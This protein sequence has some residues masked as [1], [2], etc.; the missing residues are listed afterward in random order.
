[1]TAAG[2]GSVRPG[3][4]TARVRDA[5]REATLAELAEHGYRGLTVEGVAARSGVHKTTVYRRWRNAD[6][7]VADALERAAAEPWP[8]PDTGTLAGDLRA[9]A[10]LV[11]AGFADPR[12]GPV[13][14]AFVL[15]AA[16][17]TD[18]ARALN[19]FFARRHEQAAAVVERAAA[20]GEV[21]AGTDAAEVV[22]VA[23]APLYYRLFITGEPAG[24]A[25][26]RPRRRGRLRRGPRRGVPHLSRLLA[27]QAGV[28]RG[29]RRG[30]AV[31]SGCGC[32]GRAWSGRWRRAP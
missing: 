10:R 32:P 23:V 24:P 29:R 20:R 8:I 26:R 17:S 31:R 2:P 13:S 9:I 15:A 3:G 11:Q 30:R 18:A 21:P 14:R 19:A 12:E 27:A 16:Q 7:L 28:R 5:V 4:R 6:G 25:G 1:M 22:R